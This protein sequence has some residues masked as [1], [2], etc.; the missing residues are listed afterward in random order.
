M[1]GYREYRAPVGLEPLVACLWE[2]EPVVGKTTRVI[3]DG[4][5]DLVWLGSE[6]GLVVAGPDTG[7]WIAEADDPAETSCAIRLRPGAAGAVLGLPAAELRDA[8]VGIDLVWGAAGRDLTEA[9]QAADP[10]QRLRVLTETVLQRR[11]APDPLAVAAARR[12][13]EPDAKVSAA[14]ADLG[15]SERQLNRRLQHAVGY[16]PKMLARVARLRRLIAQPG[17]DPLAT[18]AFTAGYASQAHMN[19]E[20]RRL[21]GLTPLQFLKDATLTAA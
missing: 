11:A 10:A 4:C 3:P 15:I 8:R 7:P 6:P 1:A 21:T 12:L 2:S 9:L 16:G 5:V 17:D 19:D 20:V 14:A 13:A 18:R